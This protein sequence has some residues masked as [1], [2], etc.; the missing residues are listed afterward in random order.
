LRF[1]RSPLSQVHWTCS[2]PSDAAPRCCA[3]KHG[4]KKTAGAESRSVC[5]EAA[6]FSPLLFQYRNHAALKLFSPYVDP[7]NGRRQHAQF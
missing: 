4:G 5:A 6:A 2:H 1:G 3:H 7:K